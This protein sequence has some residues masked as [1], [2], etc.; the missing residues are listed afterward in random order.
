[1]ALDFDHLGALGRATLQTMFEA[2]SPVGKAVLDRDLRYVFINRTLAAFN[3]C[4][5][6]EHLGRTVEEI[7]P[8]A[9]PTLAPLLRSVLD[10]GAQQAQFR[11]SVEMPN[12]PGELSEW[13]ASY[14]PIRLEDGSVGGVY[15]Q[16]VN[17]TA[18]L[19]AEQALANSEK[20]LRRVL[21]SLFAFV[22]V[23][24]PDGTLIEA[25]RA[26]LEAAGLD[27]QDVL[28]RLFWDTFWWNFS[29]ET[30]D[31][32]RQAC[33]RAAQG[34]IVRED[35]TVRMLGDSRMTLDFMLVPMRDDNG[36]ITRLIASAIDISDRLAAQRRTEA[37]LR[38]RTVLLQEVHHRVKNNLQIIAS[39]LNLQARNAGPGAQQALQD[40]QSRVM[41]MALTHQLLYERNDFSMLEL[42]PYLRRLVA[43]LRDA[44]GELLRRVTLKVEAPDSG[45]NI[46]L[47]LAVPVALVVNELL[48]N[49]LKHGFGADLH[50]EV[51]VRAERVGPR[52]AVT[53]ADTG[54][55]L[56]AGFD[57]HSTKTLGLC[58][59][60]LLT[61]QLRAEIQW[62]VVGQAGTAFTLHL[63]P[64]TKS[65]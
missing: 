37:A 18:K 6:K 62:P 53:V 13:D 56:P 10:E 14:L 40:S 55:G 25:N 59:V 50:G 12:A 30:Q 49:A 58:L 64:E 46:D 3:G 5:V 44:H 32:L 63:P 11:V 48:T 31:W 21:D 2:D 61:E 22:G 28:G 41:A 60:T 17:L 26:P 27:A 8:G 16:A 47:N 43:S 65:P 54:T 19:R 42:G 9:Y 1:M 4:S 15:V 23:L 51:V 33:A 20:Q 24:T 45:L 7:L 39:L 52:I 35:V 38:E 29:A 57:V 34:D 36:Q